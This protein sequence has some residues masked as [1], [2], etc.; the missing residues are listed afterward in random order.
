MKFWA[1]FLVDSEY[2]KFKNKFLGKISE[3][4]TF[5]SE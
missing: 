4:L 3:F 5:G 1:F 2:Q